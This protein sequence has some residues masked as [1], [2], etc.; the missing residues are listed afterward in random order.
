MVPF[1]LSVVFVMWVV[2]LVAWDL[3]AMRLPDFLTLP[4]AVVIG[5]WALAVDPWLLLGGLGW[6]LLYL[7]S[8][9]V[10]GGIGGGDIKFALG[11]GTVVATGGVATW[12]LAVAGSSLITLTISGL[13]AGIYAGGS[14]AKI[15]DRRIPHGP[16]MGIASCLALMAG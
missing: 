15:R 4:G 16:G 8:A 12:M 6:F 14:G 9:G 2:G 11:L 3:R 10:T 5:V 1:V 13:V 7:V